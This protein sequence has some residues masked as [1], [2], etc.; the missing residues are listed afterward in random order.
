[1]LVKHSKTDPKMA[2]S[3]GKLKLQW[4]HK[5]AFYPSSS[6][7]EFTSPHPGIIYKSEKRRNRETDSTCD[8]L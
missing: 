3:V 6:E 8:S 7:H 2:G 5:K 4:R 1:M